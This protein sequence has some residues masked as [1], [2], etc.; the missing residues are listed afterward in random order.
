MLVDTGVVEGKLSLVAFPLVP[1]PF[2]PPPPVEFPIV[3]GVV[4]TLFS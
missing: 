4:V 1:L 3:G 2:D